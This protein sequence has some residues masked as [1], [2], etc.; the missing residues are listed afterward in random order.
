MSREFYLFLHLTGIMILFFGLAALLVLGLT[1]QFQNKRARLLGFVSHG[2]GLFLMIFSGFGLAAKL[3]L[4]A[5]LPG[6]LY[7]KIGVWVLLGASVSLLRRKP[8]LAV[9]SYA[10]II[11]LGATAAYMGLFKPF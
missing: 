1:G 8:Q 4:L 6:W 2:I 7:V 10:L 9:M 3:G 11:L 5:N